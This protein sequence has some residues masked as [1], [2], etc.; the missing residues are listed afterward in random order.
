M[1][2]TVHRIVWDDAYIAASQRMLIETR[3]WSTR[4]LYKWWGWWIPRVLIAA[5]IVWLIASGAKVDSMSYA[6][7]VGALLLNVFGELWI[8][9]SL[10]RAR[11]RHRNRGSTTTV[12][13]SEGGID[14][15]HPLGKSHL[16]WKATHSTKVEA[17]G[18]LLM[19]SSH[20]GLWLPDAAL[21]EGTPDQVRQLV[22]VGT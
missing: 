20:A 11:S 6:Y 16:N 22:A 18:V 14:T 15:V 2:T 19:L 9:R 1:T 13:L 4:I 12:T 8:Y 21:A 5:Y 17:D 10:V 3:N 7:F